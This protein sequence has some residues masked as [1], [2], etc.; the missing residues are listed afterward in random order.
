LDNNN[1]LASVL[2]SEEFTTLIINKKPIRIAG[3]KGWFTLNTDASLTYIK[4]NSSKTAT[5]FARNLPLNDR[6]FIIAYMIKNREQALLDAWNFGN[7][8]AFYKEFQEAKDEIELH[9]AH[10]QRYV[11]NSNEEI[12]E[13]YHFPNILNF[14]SIKLITVTFFLIVSFITIYFYFFMPQ[15]FSSVQKI[16]NNISSNS[17]TTDVNE[18]FSNVFPVAI[19][20]LFLPLALLV[21]KN[22]VEGR[23]EY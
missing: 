3:S 19:L 22:L 21:I 7:T 10:R 12:K 20:L 1:F 15:I 23:E 16:T 17:T 5:G 6:L 2:T 13:E 11:K 8:D 9:G 14:E 4:S 18:L